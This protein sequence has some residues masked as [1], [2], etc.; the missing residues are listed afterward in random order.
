M[1]GRRDVGKELTVAFHEPKEAVG[2]ERLHE[3]LHRAEAE[4]F[5]KLR[6]DRAAVRSG[7]GA[8]MRW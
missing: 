7:G 3:A 1:Q 5:L 2:A 6:T 4:D 8:V